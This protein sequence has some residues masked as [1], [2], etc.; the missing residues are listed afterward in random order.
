MKFSVITPTYNREKLLEKLYDS[1]CSNVREENDIQIEWIISDDGSTDSTDIFIEHCKKDGCIDIKYFKQKNK[2]KMAAIN[3]VLEYASGEYII[4]CDS[5][6]YFTENAFTEIKDIIDTNKEKINSDEIYGICF[7]KYDQN[8]KNMGEKFRNAETTMFDLYFKE[9]ETGEKSIVFKTDIRKKYEY[10]LEKEERFSTEARMFH[11]MDKK[12]KLLCINKH[13]MICEYQKEGYTN[14]IQKQFLEN[15]YG[16]YEYF[17]EIFE[18]NMRKVK[19]K[20]RI[21]VIKHYILFSHIIKS[22]KNIKN[23]KGILNKVIY[24]VLFI[25]G[26]IASEKYLKG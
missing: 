8:M 2:G 9:G 23:V 17:K 25:P 6:D 19:F 13:I 3:N 7:L 26:K 1:L 11:Q 16:Y 14:N 12:Y 21:Y 5:D 18:M 10:V 22:K 20:K 4:E 24:L 15:P